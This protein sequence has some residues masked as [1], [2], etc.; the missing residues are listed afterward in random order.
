MFTLL[1]KDLY[2]SYKDLPVCLYQ[3]QNKYRDEARPRAGLLRGRE[4]VMK[5]AYSFDRDADGARQSYDAMYN[6][7][8]RIF[9]RLGLTFRPVEAD[10]GSIGGE[11]SHE[12]QVIAETGEDALV[13]CPTS[14][15]AAN[16]EKAECVALIATRASASQALTKTPTPGTSKCEDVATLLNISLSQTVK[17]IV[18]ATEKLDQAGAVLGSQIWLLLIRGDHDLNEVKANKV[19]GLKNGFRFASEAEIEAAFGCKPGYLGPL[20]VKDVNIVADRTVANMSDFVTGANALDFHFSGVNWGRDLPEPDVVADIRNAVAGDPSPDGKGVL[21]IQRGIEVGHVFSGLPYPQAMGITFLGE[22]GKPQ[23]PLMGSYGIGIT[24][25]VAAA[26]EQN[27]DE[28]GIIWPDAMAPFTVV[29]AP[30]GYGKSEAVRRAATDLYESLKQSNIDVLLDDRDERPGAMLADLE[31][32][33]IPHR[34]VI[35]DRRLKEGE[36][37]VEYQYRRDAAPTVIKLA[38]AVAFVRSAVDQSQHTA[39]A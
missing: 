5:D 4:F 33:G 34:I 6:A 21:E 32:I 35:G 28:R 22:N 17:S 8:V 24:R 38:D 20:G 25:V 14:D 2:N 18:L 15:Y 1:V 29:I 16:M 7:Y 19:A 39:L 3:I 13:Y 9:N 27:H 30:I 37:H 23:T 10:T 26:I 12:F 11:R 31:L 36:G